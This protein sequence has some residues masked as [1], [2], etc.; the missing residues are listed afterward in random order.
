MVA[1]TP[2]IKE[3]PML[4]TDR[5]GER[6]IGGRR[7]ETMTAMTHLT[8]TPE[9]RDL[10]L[11]PIEH[12]DRDAAA[13]IVY[14]AFA[15]IAERHGFAPDF[16][17]PQSALELTTQFIAHPSL[18]GV[19]AVSG[20]RIVGSNF[21]DER[22]PIRGVGPITVDPKAQG[23]G[24]GRRLMEAVMARGAGAA[25]IR[26]LQ[27]SF[28]A[29]SL[30][31]YASLGF[32][33]KEPVVVMSGRPSGTDFAG[34]DVR[35]LRYGD[36]AA[37]A[38]LHRAVHGFERTRELHDSLE[39]PVLEPYVAIREGRVVAYATTLGFFAAAHAVAETAEDMCALIAGALTQADADASFLLPTRQAELFRWSLEAGLRVVK[40]MTYMAIGEYRE[41]RGAWMPS[42]LY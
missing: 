15:G 6:S 19:V 29:Q 22:G 1:T 38:D 14:E 28:N 42:V 11:R 3:L 2:T 32:E 35:P 9:A 27:D 17:T 12:A 4:T 41:P 30:S 25:G 10:E 26:L 23:R 33:V 7:G 37:C 34:I 31:L 40:P 16:P 39:A 21:L 36:L 18:W 20:G 24:V 13:R 5:R 8:A